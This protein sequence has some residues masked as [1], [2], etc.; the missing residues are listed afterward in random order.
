MYARRIRS[1]LS[2]G[3]Y[4]STLAR[5]SSR[6]IMDQEYLKSEEARS[7]EPEVRIGKFHSGFWLLGFWLLNATKSYLLPSV[8]PPGPAAFSAFFLRVS[9]ALLNHS[10]AWAMS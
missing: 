7:Q 9:S 3:W 2:P 6:R 8:I 1:R 4:F 10:S 5:I